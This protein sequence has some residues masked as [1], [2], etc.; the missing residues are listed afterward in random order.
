M[1]HL[2]KL[3]VRQARARRHGISDA[4]ASAMFRLGLTGSAPPP[5]GSN[6]PDPSIQAPSM[7]E[8]RHLLLQFI[9][10]ELG[11][12]LGAADMSKHP[13][14]QLAL[15]PA[16]P[17]LITELEDEFDRV[18][19]ALEQELKPRGIVEQIYVADIA[20]L[21]WEFMRLRRCKAGIINA[22]FRA[23]LDKLLRQLLLEPGE[24]A[25]QVE[26]EAQSLSYAWFSDPAVKKTGYRT[27]QRFS[28][29]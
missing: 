23:A 18:R 3:L 29:R 7:L 21:V 17:L 28:A 4:A 11:D 1:T 27:A 15:L 5:G 14:G 25:F 10:V 9:C 8:L 16:A 6:R 2:R 24:Y 19:D 26:A 12:E 22:A 13:R 20:Y